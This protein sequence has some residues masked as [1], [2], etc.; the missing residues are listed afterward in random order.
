MFILGFLNKVKIFL[1]A[2]IDIIYNDDWRS[3]LDLITKLLKV[4]VHNVFK[5]VWLLI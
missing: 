2:D 1:F 4:F 5:V 3:L